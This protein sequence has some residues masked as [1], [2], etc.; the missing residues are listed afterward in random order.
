MTRLAIDEYSIVV[1]MYDRDADVVLSL[2]HLKELQKLTL[3]DCLAVDHVDPAIAAIVV[4]VN[5]PVLL[6]V[7][8]SRLHGS[9][10]IDVDAV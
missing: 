4:S 3:Y 9:D 8:P 2:C 6:T 5:D 1:C 7:E 10:D